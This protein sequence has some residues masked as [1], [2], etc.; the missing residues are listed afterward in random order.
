MNTTVKLKKG[1]RVI[2]VQ[3]SIPSLDGLKG[4]IKSISG[5]WHY[6]RFDG[7]DHDT[8]AKREQLEID[9]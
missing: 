3:P 8:V 1:Q 5:I 2:Y 9:K 7:D 6:V 4:V